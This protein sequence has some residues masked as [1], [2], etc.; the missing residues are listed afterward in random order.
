LTCR[1]AL[2]KI[3]FTLYFVLLNNNNTFRI[4][5]CLL[6]LY[7]I[8]LFLSY[9][10]TSAHSYYL[11]YSLLDL[12]LMWSHQRDLPS[13]ISSSTLLQCNIISIRVE[14]CFVFT[15]F[16]SNIRRFSQIYDISPKTSLKKNMIHQRIYSVQTFCHY[17]EYRT[18]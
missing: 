18:S 2:G 11:S 8:I 13:E 9:I 14:M 10:Y 3:F 16:L 12:F 6:S 7:F 5:L 17:S 15:V 4:A 1:Y